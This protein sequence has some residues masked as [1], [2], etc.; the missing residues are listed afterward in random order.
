[1]RSLGGFVP[2]PSPF[3]FG[4]PVHNRQVTA[5]VSPYNRI[6]VNNVTNS[7]SSVINTDGHWT[8]WAR[9]WTRNGTQA[10]FGVRSTIEVYRTGLLLGG[11][12][13][14]SL[15]LSSISDCRVH[16]SDPLFRDYVTHV[17]L[18]LTAGDEIRI[19]LVNPV[20]PYDVVRSGMEAQAFADL[21]K[22]LAQDTETKKSP[23]ESLPTIGITT[24][25]RT[26]NQSRRLE[27]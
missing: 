3:L 6:T 10:A 27:G 20:R 26:P 14:T 15:E 5:G 21:L 9:E 1:M 16:F 4:A 22:A 18:R 24:R 2:D 19:Q 25:N 13:T 12:P 7:S 11:S 8:F 23:G 17:S